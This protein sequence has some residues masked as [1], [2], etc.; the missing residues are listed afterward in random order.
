M[1][2]IKVTPLGSG[3]YRV[4]VQEGN[5]TTSHEVGVPGGLLDDL[6]L[7]DVD[8]AS[9]VEETFVFLLDREPAGSILPRF[10][11]DQVPRY[12]PEYYDELRARLTT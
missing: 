2:R 11:L 7:S 12:F 6:G 8:P 5:L 3:R 4:E 9:L 1:G 10:S